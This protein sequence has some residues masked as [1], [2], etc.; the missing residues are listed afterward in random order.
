MVMLYPIMLSTAINVGI[1]SSV[2]IKIMTETMTE[3]DYPNDEWTSEEKTSLALLCML[4]LGVG[5]IVGSLVFGRII[6]KC[7]LGWTVF[8]NCVSVA[9]SFALLIYYG[10]EYEFTIA[11]ALAMS[12]SFGVQDAAV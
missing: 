10:L 8:L 6:D 9:V 1:F 4:G 2:F 12:T 7:K 5:E 3:E 11:R